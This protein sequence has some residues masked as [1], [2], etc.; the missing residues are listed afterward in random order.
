MPK[1]KTPFLILSLLLLAPLALRA[2]EPENIIKY[3]QNMMKAI[4]SH[5]AAAGAIIQGK[6]DYKKDLA[7]HAR[8]LKALTRDIPGLFPPD[9]DFG[10][11]KAKNE[12]WSKRADFE[13]A[14]HN[15]KVKVEAFAKAVQGGNAQTIAARFKDMGEGCKACHKDFRQKEE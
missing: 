12:V 7:E 6:V 14:A 8:A 1:N 2:A 11:T 3:R 4:G 9:S 10:D 13:K 15:A 5:T